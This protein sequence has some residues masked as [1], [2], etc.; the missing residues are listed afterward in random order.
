MD[1]ETDTTDNDS[2]DAQQ[3]RRTTLQALGAAGLALTGCS[4][5]AAAHGRYE[6]R[7]KRDRDRKRKRKSDR[8]RRRRRGGCGKWCRGHKGRGREHG[9]GYDRDRDHRDD[10]TRWDDR[11]GETEDG[12]RDWWDD[13]EG[14]ED[15]EDEPEDDDLGEEPGENDPEPEPEP[16]ESDNA[17]GDGGDDESDQ[18]A[19]GSGDSDDDDSEGGD[20]GGDPGPEP[21]PSSFEAR[22]EQRVHAE[23]NAYRSDE[24][25]GGL[26][27]HDDLASVARA[28]SEDM[29]DRDYFDHDNLEGE[30]PDDRLDAAG[31]DC[32]AWAEN[33][34]WESSGSV[35]DEDA[36]SIADSTVEGWLDSLGH[37]RNIRGDYEAEGIGVAVT[38]RDVYITQMFCTPN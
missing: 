3:N 22:V 31:I 37:R 4:A 7:R 12:D 17:D 9:W 20:S 8:N 18:G 38:G 11:D 16:D 35:S 6:R 5:P 28:H 23:I 36:D 1:D 21:E 14:N 26:A 29:A 15:D 2:G 24:G 32:R 25:L 27:Y 10:R 19:D 13:E 33:I 30:G 34:A